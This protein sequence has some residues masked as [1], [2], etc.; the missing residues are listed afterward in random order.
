M[1][2][3]LA[4]LALALAVALSLGMGGAMAL[5]DPDESPS[6]DAAASVDV[7]NGETV[8]AEQ[9]SVNATTVTDET[10]EVYEMVELEESALDADNESA[11]GTAVSANVSVEAE[12]LDTFAVTISEEELNDSTIEV[13][14][15]D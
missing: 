13:Q 10:V 1:R 2:R 3:T 7:I 12:E 14:S 6:D 11:D 15:D 5:D 9:L 8:N 4:T